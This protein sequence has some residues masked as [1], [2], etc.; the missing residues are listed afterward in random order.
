IRQTVAG[1]LSAATLQ[2]H[3]ERLALVLEESSGADPETLAWHVQG[4]GRPERAAIYAIAAA[5]RAAAA[6]AFDRAAQL[7]RLAPDLQRP[8]APETPEIPPRRPR[9]RIA[10]RRRWPSIAPRSSI[11]WHWTSR[12]P[13]RPRLGRSTRVWATRSPGPGEAT[14]RR[15]AP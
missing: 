13:A 1:Q 14:K 4:A 15:A 12:G 9:R 11:D 8:S 2:H 7:Y 5:D 6:L 10:R 3:H